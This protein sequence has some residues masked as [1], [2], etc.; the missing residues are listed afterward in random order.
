MTSHGRCAMHPK[1]AHLPARNVVGSA[2]LGVALVSPRHMRKCAD[3]LSIRR[4]WMWA[5]AFLSSYGMQMIHVP[6]LVC[7]RNIPPNNGNE[8]LACPWFIAA[9]WFL[10]FSLDSLHIEVYG[11]YSLLSSL[12]SLIRQPISI[13]CHSFTS[14]T[15]HLAGFSFLFEPN[16]AL[17][18]SVVSHPWA[19]AVE[20]LVSYAWL[21]QTMRIC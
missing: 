19:M 8:S 18:T 17:H 10:L 1:D 5:I 12:C 15:L 16:G 3:C 7:S 2:F 13:N 11:M 14:T 21:S 9:C 4:N 20:Y 6:I